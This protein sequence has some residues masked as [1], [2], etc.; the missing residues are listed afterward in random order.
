MASYIDGKAEV[1]RWIRKTIP[2]DGTILD[3]GACDGVWS[4]LLFEYKNMDAVEIYQPNIISF[5]LK[6]KYRN[7]FNENIV[8]LRYNDYDLIIFGDIVEHLEVA[9]AQTVLEYANP[10]CKELIISV[11]WLYEQNVIY[12]NL[13]ERHIQDDLTPEIFR[14][15]YGDY[16]V[17]I[18]PRADY[19]YFIKEGSKL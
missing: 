7:V 6:E 10:R 19:C 11:P 18:A 8:N 3:V 15:R 1:L 13:Y 17:L 9:D 14:E 2:K 5:R 4:D 12:G 16:Q